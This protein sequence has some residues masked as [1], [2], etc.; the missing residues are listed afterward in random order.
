MCRNEHLI[1]IDRRAATNSRCHTASA[2]M[3]LRILGKCFGL[4]PGWSQLRAL[5]TPLEWLPSPRCKRTKVD[6]LCDASVLSREALSARNGTDHLV[7]GLTLLGATSNRHRVVFHIALP[8][9]GS[10][11]ANREISEIGDWCGV[12]NV[13]VQGVTSFRRL[14]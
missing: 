12:H 11:L 2:E 10:T 3:Q 7:L 13:I 4:I 5:L 6:S 14:I 9:G 1:R 8:V